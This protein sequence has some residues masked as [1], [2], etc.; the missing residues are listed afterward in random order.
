MPRTSDRQRILQTL[1]RDTEILLLLDIIEDGEHE[2]ILDLYFVLLGQVYAYRFLARPQV[3]RTR[4][5][6]RVIRIEG[7]LG[8]DDRHFRQEVRMSKACFWHLVGLIDR[9]PVF[10]NRST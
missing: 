4:Y 1:E 5:D 9:H 6:V 3:Y 10:Y 7:V 8:Y 2:E